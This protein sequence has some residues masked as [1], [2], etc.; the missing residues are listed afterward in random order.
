MTSP[1]LR[2]SSVIIA[3]LCL[4]LQTFAQVQPPAEPSVVEALATLVVSAKTP[5]ERDRLLDERKDLVTAELRKALV[6]QAED[7]QDRNELDQ[8]LN[9]FQLVQRIAERINDKTGIAIAHKGIGNVLQAQ[10]KIPE[11]LQAH[12]KSLALAEELGDKDLMSRV[13]NNIGVDYRNLDKN[14]VAL[15]Y[16]ERSLKAASEAG[17]REIAAHALANMST[18]ASYKGQHLLA[19]E[20]GQRAL[21]EH[22]AIGNKLGMAIVL[23]NLGTLQMIMGNLDTALDYLQRSLKLSESIGDPVTMAQYNIGSVYLSKGDYVQALDWYQKSL[24][25]GAGASA[26]INMGE[27]YFQ[28]GD[29]AQA[30][31]HIEA[32]LKE[33]QRPGYGRGIALS[34]LAQVYQ[35][36]AN[37]AK[38]LEHF[39]SALESYEAASHKGGVASSLRGMGNSYFQMNQDAQALDHFLRSLKLYEE[40]GEPGG[41]AQVLADIS[42]YYLRRK[43]YPQALSYALRSIELSKQSRAY[44]LKGQSYLGLRETVKARESFGEAI[45]NIEVRRTRVAGGNDQK[46]RFMEGNVVAYHEMIALLLSENRISEALIFAERSKGRVLLDVL[47]GDKIDLTK[48]MTAQEKVEERKLNDELTSLNAQILAESHQK[49]PVQQRLVELRSNLEKARLRYEAFQT[50]LYS[51]HPNLRT[52]RGETKTPDVDTIFD[53]L[54]DKTAFLEYVVS[55][56][57]TYV[58]VLTKNLGRVT[59]PKVYSIDIKQEDLERRVESYRQKLATADLGFRPAALDLYD[60]LL[61][62]TAD[63]LKGQTSLVVVPDGVLWNLPFQALQSGTQRYVLEDHSI[64]YAPSL[65]VLTE[66]LKTHRKGKISNE[67]ATLLAFGNPTVSE[68]AGKRIKAVLMD[69]TLSPLPE[70]EKQVTELAKIYGPKQSRVYTG[71]DAR[72]DRAKTDLPAYSNIQFA[73]HGILNSTSPM[74]SHLLLSQEPGLSKEDGLLEAWEVMNLNLSADVVVLAACETARGRVGAGEGMIGMSWA[75]FVAGSPTTVA[76]QWK[77][78]SASTTQLMLEFHRNLKQPVRMS[79]SK[80]LQQ[81]AV[82]LMKNPQYKHPFYWAPFVLIGDG[83]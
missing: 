13:L 19:I 21:A 8:A 68:Q 49:Q 74:Y 47:Q 27:V 50:S 56:E 79:K 4:S 82:K 48:S 36:Q 77:V 65:T 5:E 46:Q 52:Q 78:E 58:F 15:S 53:A 25:N 62:P 6:K 23:G 41:L 9:L 55:K 14:E 76:S 72:E 42:N 80:A 37:H 35:K 32:V 3:T 66:I 43:D 73:T 1:K 26:L 30:L 34:N 67:S 17:S 2:W 59:S 44:L 22:E 29:Y 40:T 11:A 61:K 7:L 54:P 38:A 31:V 57:R 12:E 28:Q 83:N 69:E 71:A 16:F 81:A 51:A 18:I 20:Y 33:W 70:A 24:D 45:A 63:Q 64:A 75:F 39:Q 10:D 60:L